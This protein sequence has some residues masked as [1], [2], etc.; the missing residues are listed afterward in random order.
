MS[1]RR[2]VKSSTS[3]AAPAPSRSD[4]GPVLALEHYSAS[5]LTKP[6]AD[7]LVH[8]RLGG[9]ELDGASQLLVSADFVMLPEHAR[10]IIAE[11][12]RVL[13]D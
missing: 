8:L 11:L 10:A 12:Q 1:N 6:N 13:P 4:E 5:L 2:K 7:P 3:S 9:V